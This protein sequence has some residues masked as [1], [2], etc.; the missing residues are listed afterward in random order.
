MSIIRQ[1]IFTFIENAHKIIVM[2]L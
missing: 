2:T 1:I